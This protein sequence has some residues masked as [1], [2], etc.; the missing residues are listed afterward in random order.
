MNGNIKKKFNNLNIY[1]YHML[2]VQGKWA[3]DLN[4]LHYSLLSDVVSNP[5]RIYYTEYM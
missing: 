2:H 5:R 4:F 3:I 1:Y